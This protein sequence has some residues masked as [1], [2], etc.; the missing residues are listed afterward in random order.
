MSKLIN[1]ELLIGGEPIQV[2][3]RGTRAIDKAV[4][5]VA[6][7][8]WGNMAREAPTDE[9]RLAGSWQLTRKGPRTWSVA[10]RVLYASFVNDGTGIYGSAGRRITPQRAAVLVFEWMGQTWFRRS[11]KGQQ[12]NPYADRAVDKASGRA[13]DFANIAIREEFE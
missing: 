7:E 12:A 10:T 11:V 1:F 13:Q 8:V 2:S 6:T 4:E 9:G 3:E 5:L